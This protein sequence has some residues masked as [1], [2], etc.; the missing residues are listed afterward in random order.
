MKNI[1]PV[2]QISMWR[3]S[4]QC[5]INGER[6]ADSGDRGE[7]IALIWTFRTLVTL[8]SAYIDL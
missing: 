7:E 8:T 6:E 3:I 5:G 4:D 1:D 2:R